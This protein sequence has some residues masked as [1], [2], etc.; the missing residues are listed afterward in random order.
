MLKV[1]F[2][3]CFCYVSASQQSRDSVQAQNLV[4]EIVLSCVPVTVT[5][6]TMRNVAAMDVDISVWLHIQVFVILLVFESAFSLYQLVLFY[7]YTC[8][9][10]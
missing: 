4:E 8:Q 7:R 6:P 3:V 1:S 9:K 10:Y 2:T 5:V